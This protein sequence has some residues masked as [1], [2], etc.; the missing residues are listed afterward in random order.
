MKLGVVKL[1][2]DLSINIACKNAENAL[3][4][5]KARGGTQIVY[6]NEQMQE[7]LKKEL[8]IL[9]ELV[10]AIKNKEFV[11]FVQPKISTI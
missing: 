4:N 9:N 10:E 1:N 6:Y 11:A 3:S 5:A 8:L 7:D 2:K